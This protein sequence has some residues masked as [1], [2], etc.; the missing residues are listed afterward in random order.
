[1]I[2]ALNRRE[3]VTIQENIRI[4]ELYR[5]KLIHYAE[6]FQDLAKSLD[7]MERGEKTLTENDR[8]DLLEEHNTEENRM[9]ISHNLCEVARIMNN[10]AEEL[11][12][13]RPIEDKYRKLLVHAL[14]AE[15]IYGEQFCYTTNN[16][17]DTRAMSVILHTDRRGGYQ[18]AQVANMISVL[19]NRKLQ[20]SAASPYMV[21]HEP[22]S[23][24]FM[25]EPG[26]VAL[27]GFCKV[28]KEN[29][30]VS[31]DHYSILESEKGRMSLILS[32]GTGSGEQASKDSERVLDLVE[33]LLEAG[34]ERE[35]AADMVNVAFFAGGREYSH[36]T[37]DICDL[38]LYDGKC[39]FCKVGGAA[40]FI[41]RGPHVEKISHDNLPLGIF[42][43][44]DI[45][46]TE[47]KL[48]HGDYVILVT[49]GVL[50]ALEG[51]DY[52]VIMEETIGHLED[53]CPGELAEKVMEAA[54]KSCGGHIQDDMTVLVAGIWENATA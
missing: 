23:F 39:S 50:E 8:R 7:T 4:P 3:R 11:S 47:R 14:R 21:G 41:K 31:G 20:L 45:D 18:A 16:E 22:K 37:L 27:T 6:S 9:L 38:N 33:K 46:T 26:F 1:M 10:L 40:S 15:S 54:L 28:T 30:T 42:R 29:E 2:A 51:D 53:V 48:A 43:N 36:P 44:V 32:D 12:H 17:D 24:V 34:Y 49:D 52:E 35:A 13:C 19:L 5:Q 25:E